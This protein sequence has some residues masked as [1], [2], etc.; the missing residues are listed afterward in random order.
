MTIFGWI[1]LALTMIQTVRFHM[2]REG[3]RKEVLKF[4]E[5]FSALFQMGIV[6]G[7][8]EAKEHP[9]MTLEQAREFAATTA[10]V[11][12][13]EDRSELVTE[14]MEKAMKRLGIK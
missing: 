1:L 11:F 9:E 4:K 6:L 14:S 2:Y 10:E 3:V 8:Q 13:L 7:W 5:K 12:G